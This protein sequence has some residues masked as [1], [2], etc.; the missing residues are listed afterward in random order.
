MNTNELQLTKKPSVVNCFILVRLFSYNDVTY[1][2]N[3]VL[4]QVTTG[5]SLTYTYT[6]ANGNKITYKISF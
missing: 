6:K 3:P 1:I 5:Q 4:Y 2:A